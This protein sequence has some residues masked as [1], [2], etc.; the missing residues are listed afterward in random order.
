MD[1]HDKSISG[2]LPLGNVG[3]VGNLLGH[4][5]VA[6]FQGGDVLKS[7]RNKLVKI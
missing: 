3:G 1:Y 6:S 4:Q 7:N 5:S 2:E